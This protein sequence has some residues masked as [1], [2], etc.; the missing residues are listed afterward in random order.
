MMFEIE[1]AIYNYFKDRKK[2]G[3][4]WYD[5]TNDTI[6]IEGGNVTALELYKEMQK[7]W[8]PDDDSIQ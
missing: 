7:Q 3:T 5:T 6:H 1:R 8:A 2:P 4:I